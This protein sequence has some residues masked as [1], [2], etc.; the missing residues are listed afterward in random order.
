MPLLIAGV[1]LVLAIVLLIPLSIVQRYRV[2]TSRRR[3]R[4]WLAT[5]NLAGIALSV[6]LFLVA[7]VVTSVWIPY[8]FSYAVMG[9]IGGGVLGI[10]GLWLTRWESGPGVLHYTPNRYL[11]LGLT[12]VVVARLAY[13]F[14]RAWQ[15]WRAGIEGTSWAAASGVAGSLAAGAVVLGYYLCYWYGVRRRFRAQK[16][17]L[18]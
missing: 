14:W 1:L 13:G 15:A 17:P 3:A 12:L 4:G 8:A 10:I 5:I 2:G 11:V 7:A 6:S 9:L 16:L 18:R